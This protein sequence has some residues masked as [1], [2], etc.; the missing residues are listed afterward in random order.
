M[1]AGSLLEFLDQSR[2][3]SQVLSGTTRDLV[4]DRSRQANVTVRGRDTFL[5]FSLRAAGLRARE[6][7]T[8]KGFFTRSLRGSWPASSSWSERFATP[9]S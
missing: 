9:R 2:R 7:D 5:H 4:A 8:L 3:E 6:M 1:A